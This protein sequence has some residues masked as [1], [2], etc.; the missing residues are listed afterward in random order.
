M[1]THIYTHVRYGKKQHTTLAQ[2][3]KLQCFL[4]VCLFEFKITYA[5][6]YT[7]VHDIR[8]STCTKIDYSDA[9]R[10]TSFSLYSIL[11]QQHN[12]ICIAWNFDKS[13]DSV[14]SQKCAGKSHQ[15]LTF[16]STS[17]SDNHSLVQQPKITAPWT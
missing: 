7:T 13:P 11:L 17:A 4:F 2:L 16:V 8:T 6:T 14:I 9:K 3:T 1:E 12:L 5:R 10:H 15:N